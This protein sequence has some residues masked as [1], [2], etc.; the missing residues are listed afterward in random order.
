MQREV[1]VEA[2]FGNSASRTHWGGEEILPQSRENFP[3]FRENLPRR[4]KKAYVNLRN[5]HSTPAAHSQSSPTK[6]T[7]LA[8]WSGK[9]LSSLCWGVFGLWEHSHC[10]A[11]RIFGSREHSHGSAGAFLGC[12]SAPI[13]P[14]GAI[15]GRGS[16]PTASLV[17][18][19]AFRVCARLRWCVSG[20]FAYAHGFP[21]VF[22][23][24][25]RMRTASPV[26]FWASRV[27]AWLPMACFHAKCGLV[28]LPGVFPG[29]KSIF[30]DS[31]AR[32][33]NRR[34]S[35]YGGKTR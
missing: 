21:G 28:S 23:G 15:S 17:R 35:S 7:K 8:R 3:P 16:T 6:S 30:A 12:V 9:A 11:W 33:W 22:S 29:L 5:E 1:V 14:L 24:F 18:F 25:A 4:G 10:S 27:C 32:S 19:R 13:A 34:L 26:R 2:G 31:L 20:L